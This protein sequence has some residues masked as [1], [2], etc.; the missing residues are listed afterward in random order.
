MAVMPA[1]YHYYLYTGDVGFVRQHWQAVVRQMQWDAQQVDSSGL[2]SVD[3][4]DNADWNVE[5]VS[6]ELT[7][8]NAL[9]ANALRSAAKLASAVGQGSQAKAWSA[10]AV[11]I[12]G[13][14]NRQLWNANTG[15]YDGSTNDRGTY[16]QDANVTAILAGIPSA[17][18][19]RR[20]VKVLQRALHSRFGPFD[21]S[22]PAPSGYTQDISPYMGS[23]NVLADFA[24]GD[25]AAALSLIRQEWGYMVNHD[26]GGVDWERIQLNGIPAGGALADSSAHAWSTGPTAALSQYVLGVSP[27]TPA[28]RTWMVAPE[29]GYLQSAQGVV[30]TPRGAIGVRWRRSR[31]K[32]F[33]VTVDAPRATSGLVYVPL[34]GAGRTVARNGT[35]V[36]SHGRAARGVRAHRVGDAVAFAQGAG[37][38]TYAWAR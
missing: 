12:G 8:A 3:A 2:F 32:L 11:A 9:Y 10:D 16:V 15:V 34:L 20:M 29:P 6:G 18:R 24:A 4:S 36:W 17:S 19:A 37:V 25:E 22:S 33:A 5:N 23:F 27:V 14:V 1:L 35:I 26:P 38:R 13:A 7:Y 21:V 28:Y 30:P 31:S